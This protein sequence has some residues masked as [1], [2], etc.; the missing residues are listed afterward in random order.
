[1]NKS[2]LGL[3]ASLLILSTANASEI[4][5]Y[6]EISATTEPS[7]G[8]EITEFSIAFEL[9]EYFFI[10]GNRT[11]GNHTEVPRFH[12]DKNYRKV[13]IKGKSIYVGG[14]YPI[15]NTTDFFATYALV[16]E[17]TREYDNGSNLSEGGALKLGFKK[18][19]N[20][21]L[22]TILDYNTESA[23]ERTG[24]NFQAK[25]YVNEDI[26]VGSRILNV[27]S[28]HKVLGVS[29]GYTF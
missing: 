24:L 29:L 3:A 23:Y 21:N 25:Y 12:P 13:K 20:S 18:A 19:F 28:R 2:L 14:V 10:G 16:S 26:F 6:G 9:S 15:N 5:N 1:M 17:T 8:S 27:F 22:V 11:I 7:S 4:M